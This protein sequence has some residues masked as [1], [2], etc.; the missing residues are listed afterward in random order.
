MI[1]I[2]D[3]CLDT[4]VLIETLMMTTNKKMNH[5]ADF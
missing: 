5:H 4:S 3:T 1:E 2:A